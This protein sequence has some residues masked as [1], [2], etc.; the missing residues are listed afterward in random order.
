MTK[1]QLKRTGTRKVVCAGLLAAVVAI[2]VVPTSVSAAGCTISGSRTSTSTTAIELSGCTWVQARIDRYDNGLKSY[3][4]GQLN[5]S[6]SVSAS[7]GTLAG[8]GIR[9]NGLAWWNGPW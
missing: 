4:S 2:P 7:N 5:N 9:G 3:Y 8:N 1:L 6:A